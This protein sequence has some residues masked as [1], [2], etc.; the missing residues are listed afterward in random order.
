MKSLA[1]AELETTEYTEQKAALNR[2]PARPPGP[3]FTLELDGLVSGAEDKYTE[4]V[5]NWR[6]NFR[7]RKMLIQMAIEE[8]QAAP[9]PKNVLAI[10]QRSF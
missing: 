1:K 6:G 3:L 2:G 8:Y 10:R 5:G 9:V 4:V 7:G